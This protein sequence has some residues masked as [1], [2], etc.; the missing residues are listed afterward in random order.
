MPFLPVY[1]SIG[2]FWMFFFCALHCHETSGKMFHGK[3]SNIMKISWNLLPE[4]CMKPDFD[5]IGPVVDK[6]I[7]IDYYISDLEQMSTT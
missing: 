4:V 2:P 6:W 1:F 3:L 5:I 7:V